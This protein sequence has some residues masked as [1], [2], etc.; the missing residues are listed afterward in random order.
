M[1]E[2]ALPT[3]PPLAPLQQIRI[4]VHQRRM[5]LTVSAS[6][7]DTLRDNAERSIVGEGPVKY[8]GKGGRGL[9]ARVGYCE[10]KIWPA[11]I[12]Y[13]LAAFRRTEF[14]SL[15]NHA[16]KTFCFL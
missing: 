3:I 7:K 8:A 6:S 9:R 14:F 12:R 16:V 2:I 13:P 5:S 1:P 15:Y 4:S 10:K 11:T